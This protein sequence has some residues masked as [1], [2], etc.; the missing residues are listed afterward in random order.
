MRSTF[1]TTNAL[2]CGFLAGIGVSTLVKATT[3]A[4]FPSKLHAG[5]GE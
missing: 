5:A 3:D 1:A 2:I 4:G